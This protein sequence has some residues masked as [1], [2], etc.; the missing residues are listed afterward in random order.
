MGELQKRIEELLEE[1]YE[2]TKKP[3][4]IYAIVEE[5]KKEIGKAVYDGNLDHY[6]MDDEIWL[7]VVEKFEKWFGKA[8][9]D[10]E[11]Q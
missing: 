11:K 1:H 4:C 5:A 6:D 7:E 2:I 9:A 8:N 3:I 10:T